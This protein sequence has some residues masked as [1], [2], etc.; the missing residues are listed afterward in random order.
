V[1]QAGFRYDG[2]VER[3]EYHERW[4]LEALTKHFGAH[5]FQAVNVPYANGFVDGQAEPMSLPG[6]LD[7]MRAGYGGRAAG[8]AETTGPSYIFDTIDGDYRSPVRC[9]KR[10]AVNISS[11]G[12]VTA[13]RV[14]EGALNGPPERDLWAALQRGQL[15]GQLANLHRRRR[16]VHID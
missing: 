3:R 2:S 9:C 10:P 13:S 1:R 6:F 5:T 12:W 15:L 7:R 4:S 16:L 14:A 8:A 11:S